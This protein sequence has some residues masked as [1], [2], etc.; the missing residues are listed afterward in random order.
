MFRFIRTYVKGLRWLRRYEK[1][2]RK[3]DGYVDLPPVATS[4]DGSKPRLDGERNNFV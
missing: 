2:S 1:F 3:A 4:G